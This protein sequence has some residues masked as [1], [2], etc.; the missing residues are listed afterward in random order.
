MCP[1]WQRND[2]AGKRSGDRVDRHYNTLRGCTKSHSTPVDAVI[3]CNRENPTTIL[4]FEKLRY[5]GW[6]FLMLAAAF[7]SWESIV[8]LFFEVIL[9]TAVWTILLHLHHWDHRNWGTAYTPYLGELEGILPAG[10]QVYCQFAISL[11]ARARRYRTSHIQE[12]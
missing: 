6:M 5:L 11:L 8:G 12:I 4:I 1:K 2:T 3:Q 10:S 7:L 9:F